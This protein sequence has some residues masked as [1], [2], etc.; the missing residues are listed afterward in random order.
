MNLRRFVRRLLQIPSPSAVAIDLECHECGHIWP[1]PRHP[2][3]TAE[4]ER[5]K[6]EVA[7]AWAWADEAPK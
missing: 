4:H 7:D 3:L 6:R 2:E 1:C 5:R